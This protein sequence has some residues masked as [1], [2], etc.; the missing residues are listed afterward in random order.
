[1]KNLLFR[2]VY[3]LGI[4]SFF[5]TAGTAFAKPFADIIAFGDSLTDVGNVAG[6][7]VPG[8]SPVINGY[9]KETHLSDNI[10]WIEI[11]AKVWKLPPRTTGRG[12]STSLPPQPH[13]NTWAWR[14]SE[15]AAGSV[16]PP[17]VTEP[18]PNLLL[19]VNQYLEANVPNPKFLYSIWSGANNLLVGGDFS[20]EAAVKAVKAVETAMRKL[21]SAGARFFLIFNMPKLGDTPLAISGGPL[22]EFASNVY[23]IA[24]NKA[25]E[26]TIKKLG[27]NHCFK[28]KIFTVDIFSEISLAF[29]TVNSGKTYV[30]DFYVPGPRVSIN[31][32]TDQGLTFFNTFGKFPKHYLFWDDVHPTTQA[33][34]VVAGLVLRSIGYKPQKCHKKNH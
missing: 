22:V 32:V 13:G 12:N 26:E 28:G 30:P 31:N 27:R 20:P 24:F 2:I 5:T 21:E 25:L 15:A 33:Y 3:I 8:H 7:T 11:L 23:S 29:D 9:Y 6:L 4:A 34:Q 16:Q 18:I 17:G 14:G 1:M 10:I 19:E